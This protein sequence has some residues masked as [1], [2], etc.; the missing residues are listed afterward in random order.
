M[1]ITQVERQK[2]NPKRFNVY[3]D[4]VFSFG[5]DEDL[6][7]DLDYGAINHFAIRGKQVIEKIRNKIV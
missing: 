5:A 7:V 6:I 4:G 1:K 3:L 2:K